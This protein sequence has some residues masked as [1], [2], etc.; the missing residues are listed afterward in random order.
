MATGQCLCGAV[1]HRVQGP[2]GDV[3]ICHCEECR[4]WHGHVSATRAVA[5]DNLPLLDRRCLRW[6]RSPRSDAQARRGFWAECGSSLFSDARATRDQH[7][8]R[9]ARPPTGLRVASHWFVSQAGDYYELP[10]DGLL[11]QERSGEG[12]L[13]D[14]P[15]RP[16]LSRT[17]LPTKRGDPTPCP[18]RRCSFRRKA[19]VRDTCSRTFASR[20]CS[21]SRSLTVAR[22]NE[23]SLTSS[24]LRFGGA[25]LQPSGGHPSAPAPG[26]HT[27][28]SLPD[29]ERRS[30]S[31]ACS[32][33]R[34][35]GQPAWRRV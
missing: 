34:R 8:R 32:T 1:R 17:P 10:E 20:G 30:R 14:V 31:G 25:S 3:L 18:T 19:G 11:R 13:P 4:R 6:I 16:V 27:V 28:S 2:L 29:T 21:V 24:V 12:E 23:S 26:R 9:D 15:A 22:R 7:R 35:I 5:R 33:P